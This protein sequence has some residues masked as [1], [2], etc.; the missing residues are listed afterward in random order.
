[1]DF[2]RTVFLTEVPLFI[3]TIIILAVALLHDYEF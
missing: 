2:V 3:V 1:M